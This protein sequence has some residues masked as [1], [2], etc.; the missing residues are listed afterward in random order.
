MKIIY[1]RL[2]F[3]SLWPI[4][5]TQQQ[6]KTSKRIVPIYIF[7]SFIFITTKHFGNGNGLCVWLLWSLIV[8]FFIL[9]IERCHHIN[10]IKL[11][12]WNLECAFRYMLFFW[13]KG[14][15]YVMYLN[16]S[17]DILCVCHSHRKLIIGAEV[18]K[19]IFYLSVR[20]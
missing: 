6:K 8:V 18:C 7:S 5:T 2:L 17:Y 10:L 11:C 20:I 4:F 3:N 9:A 1:S 19:I 13:S 16:K 12:V 14:G 15:L